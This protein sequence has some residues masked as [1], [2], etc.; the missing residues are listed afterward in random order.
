MEERRAYQLF[1]DD[2]GKYQDP[3]LDSVFMAAIS[4]VYLAIQEAGYEPYDQL[5]GFVRTGNDQYITR[6]RNARNIVTEMDPEMIKVYLKRYGHMY[7]VK[8]NR[9][10]D[11]IYGKKINEGK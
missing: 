4:E 9:E 5:T 6:R 2:T 1:N 7:V 11:Y 3:T 8:N 10:E